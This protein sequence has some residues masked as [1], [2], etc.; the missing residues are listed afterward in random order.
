MH[1]YKN[2]EIWKLSLEFCKTIYFIVSQFPK[3][4]MFG[5]SSQIK[6][7]AVSISSNIA[8]GSSR[9]SDK[10]FIRFLEIA[11]GSSFELETQLTIANNVEL[12]KNED[13]A[14]LVEKLNIIQKKTFKFKEKLLSNKS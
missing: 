1:N 7:S 11:L 10:D 9:N 12:L 2:L 6:R 5:L 3:E 4:E 8:E 13:Y 14:L